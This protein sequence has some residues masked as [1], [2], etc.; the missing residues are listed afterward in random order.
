MCT[1]AIASL[2][3]HLYHLLLKHWIHFLLNESQVSFFTN[4]RHRKLIMRS[5]MFFKILNEWGK[6]EIK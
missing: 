2:V 1:I 6:Y 4:Y 5:A 3:F